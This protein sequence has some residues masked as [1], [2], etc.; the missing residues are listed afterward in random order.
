MNPMSESV[1]ISP[2]IADRLRGRQLLVTG[3]T[4]LLAKVFVEKLLR[5]VPE[6]G[7]IHLLVRG[8]ADGTSSAERLQ[9]EVLGSSVFGRL[10]ASLGPR[11][12]SL[13]AE[14]I[15]VVSGDL[16]KE[17]LGL[18][19][20]DYEALTQ[21]IDIVVN[22][23]A[24]V[25]FDERL[26]IAL[27][28]N[29]QGP[30]R[31]LALARDCG[32]AP[33]MQVSTCY[34]SGRRP[35]D[36]AEELSSPT[37]GAVADLDGIVSEMK[38]LASSILAESSIDDES[39]RRKLIAAGMEYAQRQGWNDTYTFTKWL[40]E[41][42]I[43]RDRGEVPLVILRPAIIEGS[44][45]E[46]VPGWIDGL[47]MADPMIIAYG[48]GKLTDFPAD[49]GVPIDI[50]PVDLVANAMIA[51]LPIPGDPPG[52]RIYQVGSSA[53]HPLRVGELI[54]YLEEAFRRRP[55]IDENGSAIRPDGFK[56]VPREEFFPRLERRLNGLLW[57]RRT[58]ESVLSAAR[59][60]KLGLTIAQLEQLIYFARIYSPYTH[61]NCRFR[62]DRLR[63]LAESLHPL[64]RQE[65]PF[66]VE[67]VDWADY[68]INR[69]VPGLRK[70]VL[71]GAEGGKVVAGTRLAAEALPEDGRIRHATQAF[72]SIFDVFQT[73]ASMCRDKFALQ[74]SRGGHWVRYTYEEAL[75][76]TAGIMRRFAEFGLAP[77]DRVVICGE[78]CP[79]WGLTY[80]AAMRAGLTAVPLDPQWPA[81]EVLS[82][83]R[84]AEAKLVC[85]GRTTVAAIAAACLT[86]GVEL[87]VV[88]MVEPFVPPPGAWR[89]GAPA[90]V[91][92]P[93]EQIASILFTSGTTVAPKAVQLTH[94][95]FLANVRAMLQMHA[96][97]AREN[98][99]SV[100]PL[101]HAFEFTAGF[102]VPITTGATITYVEQLKGPE[103]VAAMQATGTTVML[104]VPRL[105]KLFHEA[106]QRK[107]QES[108]RAARAA[109]RALARIS[110]WSGRRWGQ[111]LFGR[112]HRQ[113]GG[114]L[115]MFVSG[116]SALDPE[117]HA[118]F[119]RMGFV[120]CEGYGLTETAPVLTVNPPG[121]GKAGSVGKSLPGVE[122]QIR[123]ANS[124]GIGELWARGPNVMRGYLKNAEATAAM[125]ENGW[126][127]TGDLCRRDAEGFYYVTGRVKD[128]IVTD[129]GKNVYPDEVEV[130]YKELPYVKEICVIGQPNPNGIGES[131]HAVIVP[132]MDA[133]RD[134]DPSS[135][136]RMIREAAAEIGARIPSHQ[137]V[138]TLHF[139]TTEL[140]KTSTLKAKRNVI[141]A[142]LLEGESVA[143]DS[144]AATRPRAA[145]RADDDLSPSE[146]LVRQVLARL[147]HKSESVIRRDGNLLL[148]LGVDSLMKLQVVAELESHFD[149]ELP[150]ETASAIARVGDL[151]A[152]VRQR[153]PARGRDRAAESWRK[154]LHRGE[155][156][157]DYAV[158]GRNGAASVLLPARWAAR[159][160]ISLFF[161]SY[162]RVRAEGLENIP[163]SGPF[164]IAP[165]HTSHL[166]SASVLTAIGDRR[167]VWVA[168]AEDYFFNTR[169][170]SLVFG[171][172]LDTIPFD[173]QAEGIHGL[174]RC[175]E[176]LERGD[177]VLFFPE[178]TRSL[179][180]RLQPFK[181]GVA[182]MSVDG[183]APV[184]PTRIEN[185]YDLFRKGQRFVRPGVVRVVFGA[186]VP[187]SP[188]TCA[189]DIEE[190]YRSYRELAQHIQSRV[191]SLGGRAPTVTAE[192]D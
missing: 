17:R 140:P 66:A 189:N 53:R 14:K 184:I 177:G 155:P 7:G 85:A 42:L 100:L 69:H 135:L 90:P 83:A 123:N 9:K 136:E 36:I 146:R 55:M 74:I 45:E 72:N 96:L 176:V 130:R 4:G 71:G 21:N 142:R 56:L 149:V 182:V 187:P 192:K 157:P 28:L 167:R 41:Q 25:T 107:V 131:V 78:N 145:E 154:R 159:G 108:S 188:W 104:V 76:A 147:T 89:D 118:A 112:I 103:I 46:P 102:L 150:D 97:G 27:A 115:R 5:S 54:G 94:A 29:T 134:L 49:P 31:L 180:G 126:L 23:A 3:S 60:R 175:L 35:G 110:E 58:L 138:Q 170:K 22:S 65:F 162:V 11:F 37:N 80:L 144:A 122:L 160:G 183:G 15:R 99:L 172:L 87:P 75:A 81:E 153:A 171:A 26:D 151:Y 174:R 63:G 67:A 39:R 132:D 1:G 16:T 19:E 158:N 86:S 165:N 106:I 190:Q 166:D 113:F 111:T 127:R 121:G 6:V 70:F 117:L 105:L 77:G 79:E 178:G 48:R 124:E 10:R 169:L 92:V 43:D 133:A 62:D 119:G 152:L 73:V 34:V 47:R 51:A 109:F 18:P 95:N 64:D 98:F 128:M 24:A 84:F 59:R 50:I 52:L 179:T 120:V 186:P 114:H 191:Q 88:A 173:R 82:G 156:A 2:R 141:R 164:I 12:E 44:L 40:G 8:L 33:F 139:W 161:R 116:G 163:A 30:S 148:D 168:G 129:A 137:R 181:M 185:A 57:Q 61:L 32:H 93:A 13:A 143:E 125:I 91:A 68:V 38:R 20:A 101:Y